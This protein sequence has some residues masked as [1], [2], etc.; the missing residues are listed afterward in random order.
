[1]FRAVV[2]HLHRQLG[3]RLHGDVLDLIARPLVDGVVDAPRPIDLAV[4]LE[5]A[6]LLTLQ[7]LDDAFDM[8]R[9]V[10]VRHQHRILGF[11]DHQVL[12]ADGRHQAVVRMH[13]GVAAAVVEHVAA[14]HVAF[15][16]LAAHVPQR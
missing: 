8:L 7:L 13:V 11:D 3:A 5:L 14:K 16:V 10:L 15:G 9:L 6:A 12:D 1:M 2:V 4:V